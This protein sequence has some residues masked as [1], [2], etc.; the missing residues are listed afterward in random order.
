MDKDEVGIP[1]ITI[2]SIWDNAFKFILA[3]ILLPSSKLLPISK[4]KQKTHMSPLYVLTPTSI[5]CV[6]TKEKPILI[7]LVPRIV[8]T[9][10]IGIHHRP[11][12]VETHIL[13]RSTQG[14]PIPPT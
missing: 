8:I 2:K 9:D 7:E 4:P 3:I 10:S 13:E 12:E 5:H 6:I 11:V 1:H 14:S